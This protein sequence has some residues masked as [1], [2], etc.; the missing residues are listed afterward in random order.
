M[1]SS[2]WPE[3]SR[4]ETLRPG[5]LGR[6]R[7]QCLSD[8]GS[9]V[10]LRRRSGILHTPQRAAS[11][12]P[13]GRQ[14]ALPRRPRPLRHSAISSSPWGDQIDGCRPREEARKAMTDSS[15]PHH[16]RPTPATVFLV[17]QRLE[18]WK[19]ARVSEGEIE[20]TPGGA[21]RL[22]MQGGQIATGRHECSPRTRGYVSPGDWGSGGPTVPTVHVVVIE[23]VGRASGHAA[24]PHPQRP[25]PTPIDRN[26]TERRERYLD[27]STSERGRR[28]A[29]TL[30]EEANERN[31]V[32]VPLPV[33]VRRPS[34]SPIIPRSSAA[35]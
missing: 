17:L 28:A 2:S 5:G 6:L 24:A 22:E 9:T 4:Q 10:Q 7:S 31:R 26:T 23:L 13:Q 11:Y 16:P 19:L 35:P 20:D 34:A 33:G 3:P 18:A 14:A 30:P 8:S 1:P 27:G 32:R 12:S 29:R 21:S 25:N 15:S